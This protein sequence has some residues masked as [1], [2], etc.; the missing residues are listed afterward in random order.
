MWIP[1]MVCVATLANDLHIQKVLF[2]LTGIG[3][4]GS[5][6]ETKPAPVHSS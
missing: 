5:R 1:V 2:A 6:G 4:Y 3:C